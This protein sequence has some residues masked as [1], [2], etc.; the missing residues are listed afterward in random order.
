MATKA[1]AIAA[2]L[3]SLLGA[4]ALVASQIGGA[5]PAPYRPFAAVFVALGVT[6]GV[7]Q[8]P[9][10]QEGNDGGNSQHGFFDDSAA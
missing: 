8:V 9:N 3:L 7:Y 2:F 5:L 10:K 1:K 4:L 6:L